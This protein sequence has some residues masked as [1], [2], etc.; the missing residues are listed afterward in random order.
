MYW[1]VVN[2]AVQKKPTTF[3]LANT[4][5]GV[6]GPRRSIKTCFCRHSTRLQSQ[7]QTW[8][9]Q[10]QIFS[11]QAQ[12]SLYLNP[13]LIHFIFKNIIPG[14]RNWY[15]YFNNVNI[16]NAKNEQKNLGEK[17]SNDLPWASMKTAGRRRRVVFAG[18]K[19]RL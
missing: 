7:L 10:Q 16:R 9:F 3:W 11:F 1:R 18:E 12:L 19:W 17:I 6:R 8:N 4:Q 15:Y 14:R 13:V 5:R 2:A